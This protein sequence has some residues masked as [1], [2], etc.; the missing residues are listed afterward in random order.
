MREKRVPAE[1][2][3]RPQVVAARAEPIPATVFDLDPRGTGTLRDE[4]NLHVGGVVG[5]LPEV[6]LIA[7][8][9]RR[10]PR[11]HLAPVAL[12]AVGGALED[13]TADATFQDDDQVGVCG[14]R[15]VAGPPCVNAGGPYGERVLDRAGHVESDAQRLA[16]GLGV[17][18]VFSASSRNRVAASPQMPSR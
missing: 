3:A 18:S 7:E 1:A 5:V 13:S 15:V 6:P 9:R 14:H 2:V 4:M 11:G 17:V 8:Q 12:R 10:I 16:H